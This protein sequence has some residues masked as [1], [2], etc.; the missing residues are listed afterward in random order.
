[1]R[2]PA[3]FLQINTLAVQ[4]ILPA[5][6]VTMG[7]LKSLLKSLRNIFSPTETAPGLPHTKFIFPYSPDPVTKRRQVWT[8]LASGVL[9]EDARTVVPWNIPF[10]MLKGYAEQVQLRADRTTWYL[11]THAVLDGFTG[12]ITAMKWSMVNDSETFSAI[13]IWLGEDHKGNAQFHFLIKKLTELLGEPGT[14]DVQ[15]FGDLEIGVVEWTNGRAR[16][17][18]VAIEQF[19]CKYRL[20]IGLNNGK[21]L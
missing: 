15:P 19:V 12:P 9:L 21:P 2:I 7:L 20:H 6:N 17:Y 3:N 11:G 16:V 5:K 4:T 10:N 18:L 14:K 1:S 13:E 8:N